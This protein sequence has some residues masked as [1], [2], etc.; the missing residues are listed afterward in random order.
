MAEEENKALNRRYVGEMINQ[1][2]LDA[3]NDS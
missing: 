2:N 3:A 1:G